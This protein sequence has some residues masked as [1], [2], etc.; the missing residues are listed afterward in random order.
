ME[1][2]EITVNARADESIHDL[3]RFKASKSRN[4]TML[5][6]FCSNTMTFKSDGKFKGKEKVAP[7]K[8]LITKKKVNILK[9]NF[10]NK[11]KLNSVHR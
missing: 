9:D 5:K 10:V 2:G 11:M 4:E 8:K 7:L 1:E 6:N 3:K